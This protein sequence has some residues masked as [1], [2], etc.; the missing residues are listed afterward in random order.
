MVSGRSRLFLVLVSTQTYLQKK[1]NLAEVYP[2]NSAGRE[3]LRK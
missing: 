3:G 1:S 2:E